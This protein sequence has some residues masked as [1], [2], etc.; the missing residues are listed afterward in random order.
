MDARMTCDIYKFPFMLASTLSHIACISLCSRSTHDVCIHSDCVH[1]CLYFIVFLNK[2]RPD[3][4]QNELVTIQLA[5][6]SGVHIGAQWGQCL[7]TPSSERPAEATVVKCMP[8]HMGHIARI[9]LY[10]RSTHDVCMHSDC[11]LF[12]L[13]FLVFLSKCRPLWTPE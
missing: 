2:C 4:R 10:S 11:M 6:H 8:V 5:T 9:S 3:G 12:C 7:P 13:C 1:F